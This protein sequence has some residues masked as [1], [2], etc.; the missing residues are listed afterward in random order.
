MINKMLSNADF[1]GVEQEIESIAARFG[2]SVDGLFE[3]AK[4][5]GF[6]RT[7][8]DVD[9]ES[10]ALFLLMNQNMHGHPV[11]EKRRYHEGLLRQRNRERMSH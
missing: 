6:Q 3:T 10:A 2:G 7:G 9:A 4:A 5:V 11:F 8:E 1:T